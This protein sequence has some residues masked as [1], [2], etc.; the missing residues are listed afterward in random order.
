[1]SKRIA[2][3]A[4]IVLLPLAACTSDVLPAPSEPVA[5]TAIALTTDRSSYTPGDQVRVEL[6]NIGEVDVVTNLCFAFL[7]LEFMTEGTWRPSAAFLGPNENTVCT[8]LGHLIRPG[9]QDEGTLHLPDD[10]T[11]GKYRVA[12]EA[13][14]NGSRPRA[15]TEPFSVA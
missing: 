2:L 15:T 8:T 12:Y 9:G 10:L 14:A 5:E 4:C 7:Y 13:S 11:P 1:M 3:A 6:V